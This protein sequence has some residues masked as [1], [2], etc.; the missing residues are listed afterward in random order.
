LNRLFL[1]LS[2]FLLTPGVAGARSA[3]THETLGHVWARPLV[4]PGSG[5]IFVGA[6]DGFFHAFAPSGKLLWSYKASKGWS[7]WPAWTAGRLLAAGS[8]NGLLYLFSREGDLKHKVSLDGAPLG[9]PAVWRDRLYLGTGAGRLDAVSGGRRVWS[10]PAGSPV[11]AW[12]IASA[13]G[14]F[15]GCEDGTVF[16]VLHQDGR[17][18]WRK[19]IT[20]EKESPAKA[21]EISKE[22]GVRGG[23]AILGADL[24]AATAD[25]TVV[26]LTAK[27]KVRWRRRFESLSGGLT[28]MGRA[29]VFGTHAGFLRCLTAEGKVRWKFAADG[30]IRGLPEIAAGR[31]LFGT[32]RGTLYVLNREGEPQVLLQASGAI[33]GGI[34]ASRT[35]LMFG[36]NHRRL[37]VLPFPL[38]PGR[39]PQASRLK[40]ML[41]KAPRGV[42]LWRREVSGPVAR[43]I[44]QGSGDSLVAGTWGKKVYVLN[45]RGDIRWT[46]N[47]GADV[48]TLPAVSASGELAF[49]CNDGGFYGLGARGD[50][51]WRHP[52]NKLL[53]SSPALAR[54]GTV[55]FGA[56]DKRLY[57]LDRQ[58]KLRWKVLTGDD[59]DSSPRIAPD[60]V[61]YV[62]SDDRHLYAVDPLGHV[63]WYV[64]A[65]GAIRSRSALAQ[66][67]TIYATGYD[68]RLMAVSKRGKIKWTFSTAGQILSSPTVG[69]Q[70]TI[71]FG[72][73]D[74]RLY[75]VSPEGKLRWTFAT[76]GEID[77][78]PVAASDG[79]VAVGSDDGNL[80]VLDRE[81]KLRWWYPAGAEIRGDLVFR[82]DRS[83][84]L[85]TMDGSVLAVRGPGKDAVA[86][87]Q[88]TPIPRKSVLGRIPVGQGRVGP[89]HLDPKGV[90]V[91][92][93]QDGHVRAY[94]AD[95]WP[96][97]TV[98][99]G[100]DRLSA[101]A[102]MGPDLYV[103][104]A[105][106]TL[107]AIRHGQLRFRLRL[108][109]S[110]LTAPAVIPP[111]G[112]P[113]KSSDAPGL[114]AGRHS[115]LVLAGTSSGRV[116]AVTPAGK[117][118][119]FFSGPS[120]ISTPPLPLSGSPETPQGSNV[121]VISGQKALGVDTSGNQVWSTTLPAGALCG[122]LALGRHSRHSSKPPRAVE[123]ALVGDGQGSLTALSA[124]GAVVWQHDLGSAV[125]SLATDPRSNTVLARTEDGRLHLLSGSGQR[126]LQ[127]FP[128]APLARALPPLDQRAWT[129]DQD[130]VV[131]SLDLRTGVFSRVLD[132]PARARDASLA[133]DG[134]LTVATADGQI[135]IIGPQ[136]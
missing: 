79:T 3:W 87:P 39:W 5:Q 119:W 13:N 127:A 60:G 18:L 92:A 42:A 107:S 122:P 124:R 98:R 37:H 1:L 108:D 69:P 117:V 47:C 95:Q 64:R 27:G 114:K 89:I 56:R 97:W 34:A 11:T 44:R 113:G 52:V 70:G 33:R 21:G 83:L 100:E 120:A 72:S 133:L 81:G 71:Y 101:L 30:P 67:G 61:V 29:V 66:D 25:G 51:R 68:Q 58:G 9:P 46:Y 45:A 109:R 77:A 12:P 26:A 85:G 10:Y 111:S 28:P 4:D 49:G 104:D 17:L 73:R 131:S 41:G 88:G 35:R 90:V 40:S 74:N 112:S 128:P 55:Y 22:K 43:G 78:S 103:T 99:V 32:D 130:G 134:R 16:G 84:V 135:T 125:A 2:L 14:V 105:R 62:G 15:A 93:G 115:G 50:L 20:Q 126:L 7:G 36:T 48:D 118:R 6:E 86:D 116:W 19:R 59:V 129:I 54:D 31:V 110:P 76:A 96:L 63:L 57:A 136:K 38:K 23:L 106:G 91:V 121:V 123:L 24:L 80:Y 8:R 132:L 82:Q 65:G 53:S 75:A 94:G 102:R